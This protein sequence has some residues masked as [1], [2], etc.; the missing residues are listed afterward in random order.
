MKKKHILSLI[1]ISCLIFFIVYPLFNRKQNVITVSGGVTSES[2]IVGNMI[3]ELINHE[4]NLDAK[5]LNNLVSAQVNQVAMEKGELNIAS[6]RYTGTDLVTTL[7]LSIEK[8]PQKA[9]DIVQKEFKNRFNQTWFPSYGF[10]NEFTFMVSKETAEKYNLKKVSDLR[11]YALDLTLGTD[12]GWYERENDGYQ[13]FSEMYD[14]SFKRVFP[15]QVGLL[16][17]ALYNNSYDVILGYSTDGRIS[18]YDLVL[19]EDD[20][21]FFPPYTCSLV[22]DDKILNEYPELEETLHR[23][24]N[25]ITTKTMQKLNYESDGKKLEPQIIAKQ[26]LEENNYFREE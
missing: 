11:E 2:Q 6:V 18:A 13:A 20:L 16:Y 26:F 12:Q 9:L 5:L 4:T 3:V 19:L 15:M 25:K 17:D 1:I 7:G 22:I 14:I 8:D 24:D 10:A 21:Q 23:L